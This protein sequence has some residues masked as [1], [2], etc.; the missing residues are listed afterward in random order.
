MRA[1]LFPL[2]ALAPLAAL[3]EDVS[4]TIDTA[5]AGPKVSPVMHGIFF[6]DINYAGDGGLYAELVENR[7]F[8]HREGLYSWREEK[9][10]GSGKM[11]LSDDRP[12]NPNN[13]HF[14]RL[15]ITFP[16]YGVSNL[17]YGGIPLK[18]G[19]AYRFSVYARAKEGYRGGLKVQLEAQNGTALAEGKIPK[20]TRDWQ[21]YTLLLSPKAT[22]PASRLAVLADAPGQVD[23][24]M[25]SLFPKNTFKGRENGM[26]A[27]LAQTIADMKPGFMRFPGG[28]IVEGFDLANAYRWKD[29]V[30]DVSQRKQNWNRWTQQDPNRPDHHYN[31]TYGL[32]FFEFFQFC[33]DIGAEPVPVLNCG[34]A[35][36]FQSK[37]LVAL[38]KLDPYVQD[39][40]DLV[41]FANGPATSK[42][43]QLRAD[44]GHP[45]PFN[46][47]YLGVGNEQWGEEY[48]KRYEIFQKALKAKYPD[49]E[50]ITTSGPG[51]NDGSW[52]LAWD[53]FRGG[54]PADIV[55]EH[56]YRPLPWFLEHADRYAGYDRNGPKVFAGEYAAH[57]KD[58]ASALD[59]AVCEAAFLTG[60]LKSA[61]VVRMS[62]YAPMLAREGHVQWTPD[63]IWFDATRVMPTPTYHAQSMFMR[64]RPDRVVPST[65]ANNT[66][67]DSAAGRAGIGTWGTQAEFKDVVV[68]DGD[69]VLFRSGPSLKGWDNKGGTW[70][71]QN[72]VISQTGPEEGAVLLVGD[73][74]WKNYTISLKA[75]KTGGREGFLVLFQ[76][77]DE[78]DRNWWN[79][80]GWGNTSHAVEIG[81]AESP[82]AP[83]KIETGRW[84]DVRVEAKGDEV[85]CYLDDKEVHR[86][87]RNAQPAVYGVAGID[88]KSGDLVIQASNPSK[89]SRT[90]EIALQN[91][92]GTKPA[93]GEVLTSASQ[94]DTNTLDRPD[95]V[96]PKP[97]T[98]PVSGGAMRY[99]M[100]PWSH[101][102][103]RVPR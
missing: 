57:R 8:E 30:G 98:V 95:K 41:E 21:K 61:D 18:A 65:F 35:C 28:C 37:Q 74:S 6:E 101:T 44:M 102:A 25:V 9:R 59:A 10:G 48:F 40:L 88:E 63:M 96:T 97:V 17:G 2:L 11:A 76:S 72:G 90:V 22:D 79:I 77:A 12:L 36:Q 24:D 80:G 67:Q 71:V 54:T 69:K 62:C 92:G 60:V 32:G 39:A 56:Y 91:W 15:D 73:P 52:Q 27:D 51:V 53:K 55:D 13:P 26:R 20:L 29:T 31:Q 82:H 1:S 103:L 7:S 23:L 94:D 42:W 84:Y 43:G 38:D 66:V 3:A 49:L 99:T 19:E 89:E 47:K 87:K 4:W 64:N 75:R 68:K 46:L 85:V 78:K 5:G 93:K 33:E 16:S 50:L 14:L 34:M 45:A 83:G 100:P 70:S 81:A 58:R 86:V